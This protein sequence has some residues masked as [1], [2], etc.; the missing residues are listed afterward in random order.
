MARYQYVQV[1][2]W[3]QN[4]QPHIIAF[5]SHFPPPW[6]SCGSKYYCFSV[7]CIRNDRWVLLYRTALFFPTAGK[8]YERAWERKVCCGGIGRLCRKEIAK[9]YACHPYCVLRAILGVNYHQNHSSLFQSAVFKKNKRKEREKDREWERESSI[10]GVEREK[11]SKGKREVD[12]ML[13]QCVLS[14]SIM[15]WGTKSFNSCRLSQILPESNNVTD[16]FNA[17]Y[18][19]QV[20]LAFCPPR[21]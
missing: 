7:Q 17:E 6:V 8:V 18:I 21:D 9:C 16:T 3:I 4:T 20:A 14:N 11:R 10:L 19:S 1:L 2:F 5:F 15:H 12:L 13:V